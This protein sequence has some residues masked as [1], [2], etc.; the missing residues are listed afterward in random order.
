MNSYPDL[1][2]AEKRIT[3]LENFLSK[4]STFCVGTRYAPHAFGQMPE[5]IGCYLFRSDDEN[6]CCLACEAEALLL[7]IKRTNINKHYDII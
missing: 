2:A 7:G 4:A 1:S 3:E 5:F 6:E